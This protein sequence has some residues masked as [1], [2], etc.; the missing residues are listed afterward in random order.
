MTAT[1]IV[2]DVGAVQL[3]LMQEN[4]ANSSSESHDFGRPQLP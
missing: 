4:P 3:K 2:Y 1:R